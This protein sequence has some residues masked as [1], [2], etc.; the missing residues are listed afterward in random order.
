MPTYPPAPPAARPPTVRRIW[1]LAIIQAALGTLSIVITL[2]LSGQGAAASASVV[3]VVSALI[4][5]ALYL[6]LA[7]QVGQRKDW[8]RIVLGILAILG[9]LAN[10]GSGLSAIVAL[11][12]LAQFATGWLP[13][14]VTAVALAF[15]G[16]AV[17]TLIAVSAFNRQTADWCRPAPVDPRYV[18]GV[19]GYGPPATGPVAMTPGAYPAV[20]Y[21]PAPDV[22][23]T[24]APGYPTPSAYD[25]GPYASGQLPTQPYPSGQY[26]SD[27]PTHGQH[28]AG[29]PAYDV[30]SFAPP[31]YESP[32]Y[33][34]P[35]YSSPSYLPPAGASDETTP[36][37]VSPPADTPSYGTPPSAPQQ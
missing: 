13:V 24:N 19:Q 23:R 11:I 22:P 31:S 14:L 9:A 2:I 12:P 26:P 21:P 16:A 32:T 17:L 7:H 29:P 3:S 30:P 34:A 36:P 28:P 20:S 6:F 10:V 4:G 15:A 27:P 5:V 35:T 37:P 8:A 1:I 33:N 18:P 25:A